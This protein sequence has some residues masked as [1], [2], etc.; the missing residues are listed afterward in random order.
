MIYY[1]SIADI[2]TD[3]GKVAAGGIMGV[4][5]Y[6]AAYLVPIVIYLEE[7]AENAEANESLL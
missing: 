2:V 4:L 7:R 5:H 6:P 3:L 1:K